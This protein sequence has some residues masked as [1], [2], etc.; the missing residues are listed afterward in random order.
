MTAPL[1]ADLPEADPLSAVVW[2]V[3]TDRLVLRPATPADLEPTWRYRRLDEVRAWI[4]TA[5]TD[6]EVYRAQFLDPQRLARTLVIELA[7]GEGSGPV[8]IGDIMLRVEDAWA[9]TEVQE[10]AR[11]T[12]A[13]LG[14][15]L[16]PA[17]GGHGYATE[18]VRAT[19]DL[20]FGPLG[21]RRVHAGCFGDNTP[22]WRLMERIGMRREEHSTATALHRSGVWMDG[23]NYALLAP[24]WPEEAAARAASG[25]VGSH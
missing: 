14:W 25:A 2:P 23:M 4:S 22:S 19:V 18:A 20:C 13:E 7:E 5:P 9:Q 17:Y 8:V 1:P 15:S 11:A 12:Q 16:D 10:A 3:R 6:P 21:L 24:E